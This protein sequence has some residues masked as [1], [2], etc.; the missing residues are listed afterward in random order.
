MLSKVSKCAF[1]SSKI[2]YKGLERWGIRNKRIMYNLS[3]PELYE[4]GVK[5]IP[6]ADYDTR[7]TIINSTGAMCAYS[8]T[9]YGRSP[10]DKRV[11]CNDLTRNDIWWGNV[12]MPISY[13]TNR[14][15]RDLA[16]KYLNTKEKLYVVDGYAGWDLDNR[17]K[18]RIVC[19]RAYHALFMKN[20]LVRP[21]LEELEKDFTDDKNID[22]HVFNAGELL[23]PQPVP[24]TTCGTSVQ[25]NFT[26]K[27][28][29]VIGTQY[30]GEMKKGIFGVMHYY[31]P[32]RGILSLHASATE[33][34]DG[35]VT[36]FF[37]LSGTGKTTL[38][39]DPKRLMLGDD[40]HCWSDNGISNIEG[41]CYAKCINLTRENEPDIYDAIKFGAIMENILFVEPENERVVD[42]KNI[43][44]TENTRCSYPLEH[45]QNAK[46]PSRAGHAKNIVFLTCDAFGVLPPVARLTPEEAMYHFI[47][48]YTAKVAG[49]EMG[50][51]DP[52]PTF[53]ACF[54]E[55]FLPL[56]PTIY[57]DMMAEKMKQHNCK[58][59]LVNTGWSGGKFG[60]GKRMKLPLTRQIIDA[61]H[62]GKLDNVQWE[63]FPCFGFE[64]PKT[65]EGIDSKILNPRNTWAD[66]E[67]FDTT[68]KKLAKSFAENFKKY[69]DKA[70]DAIRSANPKV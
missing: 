33:G 49:T 8:G 34:K 64:I 62:E 53:S 44:I 9:R 40:E 10:K 11:V 38:S 16:I 66:K 12:N 68:L 29:T 30:A 5:G 35:D 69:E 1:G 47:S 28:Y 46:F 27:T 41:G 48:G 51:I 25:C 60:V 67:G 20:M 6:A 50:I 7:N 61:I 22:F 63:K 13:D 37:G 54:G 42:Y 39:A 18:V 70:S 65:I 32:K 23:L 15:C 36:L 58:A 19:T 14:F 43:S 56:H 2:N 3:V 59:W 57:A 26:D 55:A 52:V 17:V 4:W 45:I 31:M 24:D 21:T